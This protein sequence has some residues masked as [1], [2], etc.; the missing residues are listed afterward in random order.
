MLDSSLDGRLGPPEEEGDPGFSMASAR[1][2]VLLL[3][4][5]A[6]VVS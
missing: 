4:I 1:S 6:R 5:F 2:L 3:A